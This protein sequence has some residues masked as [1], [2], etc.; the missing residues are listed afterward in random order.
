MTARKALPTKRIAV[1][2]VVTNKTFSKPR[3]VVCRLELSPP[4]NAA[5]ADAAFCCSSIVRI[6][7]IDKAICIH[8][9]RFWSIPM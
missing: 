3:L 5:P 7:I 4:P 1:T 6:N 9:R 8:G 2:I